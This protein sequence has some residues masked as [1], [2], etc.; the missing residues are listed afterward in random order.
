MYA[1]S[2]KR[3]NIVNIFG[4]KSTCETSQQNVAVAVQREMQQDTKGDEW[5]ELGSVSVTAIIEIQLKS[6]HHAENYK[7]YCYCYTRQN[8]HNCSCHSHNE[9]KRTED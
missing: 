3:G 7:D 5:R 8:D 4:Q 6:T 1:Y 2:C 9:Q